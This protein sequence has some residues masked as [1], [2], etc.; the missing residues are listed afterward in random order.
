MCDLGMLKHF[1]DRGRLECHLLEFRERVG[2]P[3]LKLT[4]LL[5][6]AACVSAQV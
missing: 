3:I 2:D 1:H 5:M 4:R 6:N